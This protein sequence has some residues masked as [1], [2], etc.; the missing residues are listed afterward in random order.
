MDKGSIQKWLTNDKMEARIG[1][2]V[3]NEIIPERA[4]LFRVVQPQPK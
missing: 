4:T 3:I 1:M 2:K